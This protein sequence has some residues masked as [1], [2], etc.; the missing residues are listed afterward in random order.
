MPNQSFWLTQKRPYLY[1]LKMNT[2]DLPFWHYEKCSIALVL[3]VLVFAM[4]MIFPLLEV[5]DYLLM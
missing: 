3:N 4:R 2:L 5:F 1:D